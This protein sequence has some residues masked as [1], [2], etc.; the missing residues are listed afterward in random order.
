MKM[1]RHSHE[2]ARHSLKQMRERSPE[3]KGRAA[4]LRETVERGI[5]HFTP[6]RFRYREHG[7]PFPLPELAEHN[8]L[9]IVQEAATNAA[10]HASASNLEVTLSYEPE[11]TRLR[12]A[13]DGCGFEPRKTAE[14]SSGD[15]FGLQIMQERAQRIGASLQIR[16]QTGA[17]TEI[18]LFLPRNARQQPS[19]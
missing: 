17:G 16:S 3:A 15:H 10:K 5:A 7:T 4:A 14:L 12:I 2:E 9:R 1:L 18:N 19:A 11:G 8:I 13:D 6:E